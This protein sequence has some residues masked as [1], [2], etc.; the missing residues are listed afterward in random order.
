MVWLAMLTEHLN[1]LLFLWSV[2]K[3]FFFFHIMT[4]NRLNV[5][6]LIRM[7]SICMFV[8][9]VCGTVFYMKC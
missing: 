1:V 9:S 5:N 3:S 2:L 7:G 8:S 6:V 4:Q